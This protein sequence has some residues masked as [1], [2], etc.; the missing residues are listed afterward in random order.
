MTDL[1]LKL[2]HEYMRLPLKLI[3]VELV[4]GCPSQD[5]NLSRP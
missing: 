3:A 2:L 1:R 4:S 5:S